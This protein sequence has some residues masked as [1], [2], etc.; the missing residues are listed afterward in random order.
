MP[1]WLMLP[2]DPGAVLEHARISARTSA[3]VRISAGRRREATLSR[4]TKSA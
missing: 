1:G 4:A 3:S 2:N